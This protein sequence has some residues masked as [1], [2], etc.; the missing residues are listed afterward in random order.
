MRVVARTGETGG[1]S[2]SKS[3]DEDPVEVV[4]EGGTEE[5]ALVGV[6]GEEREELL[7]DLVGLR[8]ERK[9]AGLIVRMAREGL[10]V[11]GKGGGGKGRSRFCCPAAQ[12]V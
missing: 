3:E 2:F 5:A 11:G 6:V 8:R 12:L 7:T 9:E 10:L 1:V 4:G